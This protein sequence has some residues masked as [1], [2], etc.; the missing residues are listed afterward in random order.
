MTRDASN[1]VWFAGWLAALVALFAV[2][3]Q[4]PLMTRLRRTGNS[5]YMWGIVLAVIGV[6]VLA[7]VA[8][9]RH[10]VNVDL[11]RE[12]TFTPSRQAEEV[13]Q[14]L[15]RDVAL[16]YFYHARDEAGRRASTSWRCSDATRLSCTCGRSIPTGSPSWR[17]RTACAST[18]PRSSRQRAG[19]SRSWARTKTISP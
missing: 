3:L 18:T 15:D 5:V 8:L 9:F 19:A 11:T 1:L 17:R 12:R 6:V 7:N 2:G 13:V 10:D 14:A 4:L 16:T